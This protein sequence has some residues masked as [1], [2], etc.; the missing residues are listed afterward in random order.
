MVESC[1]CIG[2]LATPLNVCSQLITRLRCHRITYCAPNLFSQ[3]PFVPLLERVSISQETMVHPLILQFNAV[4]ARTGYEFEGVVKLA[5]PRRNT[6]PPGPNF[7]HL[8]TLSKG[9]RNAFHNRRGRVSG[10]SNTFKM[11]AAGDD[12]LPL[13][14][15]WETQEP[16]PEIVRDSS[17]RPSDLKANPTFKKRV[18]DA[19]A[20]F[21]S[22]TPN[23]QRRKTSANAKILSNQ[24]RDAPQSFEATV[25]SLPNV[26]YS[27]SKKL[28]DDSSRGSSLFTSESNDQMVA[29]QRRL[30]EQMVTL[31]TR[32]NERLAASN[33][34]AKYLES[35]L[36]TRDK[37]I[38]HANERLVAA[39]L[40]IESL[41]HIAQ[42]A[43]EAAE[44]EEM[45]RTQIAARL[46]TLTKRLDLMHAALRRDVKDIDAACIK[47]VPIRW[48][49]MASDIR[50][51]GSF[52]HWTKG[53]AMSPEFIEGGNNVFVAD[54]M[55]VSGTYEIKFVVDGIWQTAPDWATTGDG[56][57]ANN[58]LVVE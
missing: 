54:L 22:G 36:Q 13:E 10:G 21:R 49:G 17:Q 40:E 39:M 26:S 12:N 44:S 42:D 52:D 47:S 6:C 28:V 15:G 2:W 45:T 35:S 55:L 41:K 4:P 57:G 58:L 9:Q 46:D 27:R 20:A 37:D 16:E 8:G 50:I 56:L 19:V 5:S 1:T 14:G 34:F 24:V 31:R 51:M 38:K 30:F 25:N 3:K 33:K 7:D 48:V 23:Q 18:E 29:S 53:V 11:S 43:V 32:L